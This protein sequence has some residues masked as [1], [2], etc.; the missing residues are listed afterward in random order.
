MSPKASKD[1]AKDGAKKP[2]PG[3][4]RDGYLGSR[5]TTVRAWLA[6]G[7]VV[8][9]WTGRGG[10]RTGRSWID[11]GPMG[12]G[13]AR[14]A[15][16]GKGVLQRLERLAAGELVVMPRR[17]ITVHELWARFVAGDTDHLRARSIVNYRAQ[18]DKFELFVGAEM[19]A[20]EV[21]FDHM[22]GFRK[23]LRKL[24]H[25]AEQIRRMLATVRQVFRFG[26][27]RKLVGGEHVSGVLAYRFKRAKDDVSVEAGEFSID[28]ARRVLAQLDPRDARYWR[29][30]VA[31]WLFAVAGPR[32]SAAL[33]LEWRDI[34]FAARTI[35]WRPELDKQGKKR[36]QPV[37][38]VVLEALWVAYG[39]RT[40]Y[41]YEG[42]YVFFRPGAT[43]VEFDARK[44]RAYVRA[45]RAGKASRE[46][47]PYGITSY[48]KAL[49]K[50]EKRAG[51]TPKKWR[52]GHG[53]KRMVI[54]NLRHA[55][56][57][58]LKA[59]SYTGN[60][61]VRVLKRS[62]DK[63]RLEE[64]RK[65]GELSAAVLAGDT[66]DTAEP[67]KAPGAA[68]AANRNQNANAAPGEGTASEELTK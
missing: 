12:E 31:T 54:G 49:H 20:D 14:A 33:A 8:V 3:F 34:D 27:Q 11:E 37:P 67:A 44:P 47:K 42:P 46:D 28:E 18:W 39:W 66:P 58:L 40:A 62:Y 50:A 7:R 32:S 21:T 63:D 52:A 22:D 23:E 5:G 35:T 57:D 26:V 45:R 10:G 2:L 1:G 15:A 19:R 51:V 41:Q 56:N 38:E 16:H 9:A 65:L 43:A 48:I 4:G 61:D 24:G 13:R 36:V 6:D 17:A 60:T 68:S 30:F 59:G 64:M 25:V 29:P 53:F 55:T